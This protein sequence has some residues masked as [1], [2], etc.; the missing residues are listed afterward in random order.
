MKKRNK[1]KVEV[2]MT[3]EMKEKIRIRADVLGVG[4][5]TIIKIALEGYLNEVER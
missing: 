4:M 2:Y 3:D 5:A 1:E